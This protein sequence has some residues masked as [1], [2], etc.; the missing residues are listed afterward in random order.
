MFVLIRLCFSAF[1][2]RLIQLLNSYGMNW[3][4]VERVE[5]GGKYG[6]SGSHISSFHSCF[7][8]V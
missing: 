5:T 3:E 1:G 7:L 4:K 6:K 2:C 8:L